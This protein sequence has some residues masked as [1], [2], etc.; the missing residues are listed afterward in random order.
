MYQ[1]RAYSKY[2]PFLGHC[3]GQEVDTAERSGKSCWSLFIVSVKYKWYLSAKP[4]FTHRKH[5]PICKGEDGLDIDSSN[6]ATKKAICVRD[7]VKWKESIRLGCKRSWGLH[8]TSTHS[9]T[10]H[11]FIAPRHPASW[12]KLRTVAVKTLGSMQSSVVHSWWTP[13]NLELLMLKRRHRLEKPKWKST[14]EEARAK[15][16]LR[17]S[18]CQAGVSEFSFCL[19]ISILEQE[20][21]QSIEVGGNIAAWMEESFI[22]LPLDTGLGKQLSGTWQLI[23]SFHL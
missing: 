23:F 5:L 6:K 10:I 12:W 20:A 16:R 11:I 4:S 9:T 15:T 22:S 14:V 21:E 13:G 3:A 1:S 7:T 17:G 18:P 19:C 2:R 8:K